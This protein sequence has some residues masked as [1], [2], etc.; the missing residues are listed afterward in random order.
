MKKNGFTL[1]ELLAVI[2]ILAILIVLVVPNIIDMFKKSKQKIFVADAQTTYKSVESYILS[3]QL[4]DTYTVINTQFSNAE[5]DDTVA[6]NGFNTSINY[7][8]IL[9]E[10]KITKFY[11]N[12]KDF[13]MTL[14]GSNIK[15]SDIK[16]ESV[17]KYNTEDNI[18]NLP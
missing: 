5:C 13:I 9:S 15:L 14:T 17:V 3:E 8:I 2:A 7:Y 6:I 18:C 1:V 4:K 12:N 11:I 16:Y 10:G